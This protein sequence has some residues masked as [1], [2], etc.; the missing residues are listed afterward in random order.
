M[1]TSP[2]L[3]RCAA[4]PL[5][6]IWPAPRSPGMTYVVRRAPLVTSTTSTCWPG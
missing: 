2:G 6:Q 1:T 3:T 4:A 5:M